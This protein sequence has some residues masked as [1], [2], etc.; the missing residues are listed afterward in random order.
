MSLAKLF[1]RGIKRFMGRCPV[2]VLVSSAACLLPSDCGRDIDGAPRHG[3][4]LLRKAQVGLCV[5]KKKVS[6]RPSRIYS[7]VDAWTNYGRHL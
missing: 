7:V 5:C 3:L 2:S 6:V 4:F 1:G